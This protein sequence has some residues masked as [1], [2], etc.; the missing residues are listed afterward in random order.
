MTTVNTTGVL[1]I[2]RCMSC[3]RL[4]QRQPIVCPHCLQRDFETEEVAATGVL[5]SWTT[6][7]K[8]PLRFKSEGAYHVAVI[9]LDK[10]MR[11]SVRWVATPTDRPGDRVTLVTENLLQTETPTFKAAPH[12]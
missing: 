4:S 5:A 8:P 11:L 7:H 6:I 9:D 12:D 1:K 10:G 3:Q 2:F